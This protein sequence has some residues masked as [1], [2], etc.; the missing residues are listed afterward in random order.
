MFAY[1]QLFEHT[2]SQYSAVCTVMHHQQMSGRMRQSVNITVIGVIYLLCIELGLHA[3]AAVVV[4][5]AAI[6]A[7]TTLS[8]RLVWAESQSICAAVL[9]RA[10]Y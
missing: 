4:D 1:S 5:R 9:P 7:Q 10:A 2:E 3:L 8:A 6:N